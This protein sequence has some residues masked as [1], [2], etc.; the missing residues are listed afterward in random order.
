MEPAWIVV[1]LQLDHWLSSSDRKLTLL[2]SVPSRYKVMVVSEDCSSIV[3][4]KRHQA[5]K[6]ER[7]KFSIS[8]LMQKVQV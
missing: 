8:I 3:E 1:L 7:L 6:K 2:L 5:R 4:R